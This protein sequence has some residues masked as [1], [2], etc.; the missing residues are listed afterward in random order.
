[1]ILKNVFKLKELHIDSNEIVIKSIKKSSK[2]DRVECQISNGYGAT[3]TRSFKIN[4]K[5]KRNR[6]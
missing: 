2:I 4:I 6:H 5:R 1:M 3:V